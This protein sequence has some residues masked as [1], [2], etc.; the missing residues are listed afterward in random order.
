MRFAKIHGHYILFR[1]DDEEKRI[2]IHMGGNTT[3]HHCVFMVIDA[4]DAI[5]QTVSRDNKCFQDSLSNSRD[6]VQAAA[7]LAKFKYGATSITLTDNSYINCPSKVTLSDQSI[8]TSGQTWYQSCIPGLLPVNEDKRRIFI[9][10]LENAK[11]MSW[12]ALLKE[13]DKETNT[14]LSSIDIVSVDIYA[15]GS[16]MIVL[17]YLK[18]SKSDMSCSFFANKIVMQNLLE[19]L[20]FTPKSV[21]YSSVPPTSSFHGWEWTAPLLDVATPQTSRR[22]HTRKIRRSNK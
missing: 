2:L 10:E 22:T 3:T 16:A 21:P 20:G 14:L 1:E 12:D 4:K 13:M 5:L 6:L 19:A 11:R 8:V 9:L 18:K 7:Q 15:P 17:N